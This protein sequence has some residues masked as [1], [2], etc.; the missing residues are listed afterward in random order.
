MDIRVLTWGVGPSCKNNNDNNVVSTRREKMCNKN[1]SLTFYTSTVHFGRALRLVIFPRWCTQHS[2]ERK[3]KQ[4]CAKLWFIAGRCAGT[5]VAYR[6][7]E[8][9]HVSLPPRI[10]CVDSLGTIHYDSAATVWMY[11]E[12]PTVRV[13]G[14]HNLTESLG[15][16]TDSIMWLLDVIWI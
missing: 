5:G 14:D 13:R 3:C 8:H 2:P 4:R 6:I 1:L 15:E 9:L 10:C 11:R 7:K 16:N 12:L